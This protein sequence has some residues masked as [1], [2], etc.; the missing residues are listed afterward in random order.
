MAIKTV[1]DW[2][3]PAHVPVLDSGGRMTRD[4]YGFM[5]EMAKA[6]GGIQGLTL[7]EVQVIAQTAQSAAGEATTA[8]NEA[9]TAANLANTN[10]AAAGAK[11]NE[12]ITYA[13]SIKTAMNAGDFSGGGSAPPPYETIEP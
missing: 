8:A 12:V 5:R 7:G 2:L 11:A 1:R 13:T 4:W 10:A 3:P 6:V 9:A